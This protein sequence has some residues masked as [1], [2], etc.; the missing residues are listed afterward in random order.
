MMMCT[1]WFGKVPFHSF[2]SGQQVRWGT[3]KITLLARFLW[4]PLNYKR[5][6]RIT[7]QIDRQ[8]DKILPQPI[9]DRPEE[10]NGSSAELGPVLAE[11]LATCLPPCSEGQCRAISTEIHYESLPPLTCISPQ[12]HFVVKVPK[13]P[14]CF[15][16]ITTRKRNI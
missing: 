14:N 6:F 5:H 10:E 1:I 8:D 16:P 3:S 13:Q 9:T 2:K 4:T 7:K 12:K 11:S 15:V